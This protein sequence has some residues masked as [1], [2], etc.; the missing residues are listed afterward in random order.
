MTSPPT[1][2]SKFLS[3]D[4]ELG[5]VAVGFSGGQVCMA[6][7]GIIFINDEVTKIDLAS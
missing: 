6:F 2:Q 3:K 5:V 7:S 4:N 1:L